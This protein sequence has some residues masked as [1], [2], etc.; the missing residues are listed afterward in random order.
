MAQD[1]EC[2]GTIATISS[3]WLTLYA[4]RWRD[5]QG[6]DL[7]YWRVEKAHSLIVLPLLG[8][9]ILLPPAQ[10]RPGLGRATLDLPGGRVPPERAPLDAAPSIL[11]REL[12]LDPAAI[13]ELYLLNESGWPVN[14][15]FSNQCLFGAVARIEPATRI[16]PAHLHRGYAHNQA[17]LQ[18]LLADL[19]CLQCRAVIYEY[20]QRTA[21]N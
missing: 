4:E 8:E 17:G 19:D 18:E 1:W 3:P 2:K 13:S 15:S 11:T 10:F 9:R 7:E 14:S 21:L 5:E 16:D 12:G 6:R 20:L